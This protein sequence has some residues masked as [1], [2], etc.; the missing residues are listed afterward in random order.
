M[1]H[2]A[3]KKRSVDFK[4]WTENKMNDYRENDIVMSKDLEQTKE[5]NM[6]FLKISQL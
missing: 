2:T 5:E 4:V 6:K 1:I 3:Y